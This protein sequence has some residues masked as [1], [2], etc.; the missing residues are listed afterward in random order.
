MLTLVTKLLILPRRPVLGMFP[1]LGQ[2]PGD[3]F[4][5]KELHTIEDEVKNFVGRIISEHKERFDGE[6][7]QDYID[8][9]LLEQTKHQNNEE[10]T[11]SGNA[12]EL[13]GH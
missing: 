2:L 4:G 3:F 9:F 7:I 10:S 6:N 5:A 12:S 8:A 11:F 1:F 13:R